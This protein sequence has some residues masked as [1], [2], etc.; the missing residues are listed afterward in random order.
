MELPLVPQ[1]F[2]SGPLY[3]EQGACAQMTLKCP[4][5]YNPRR[6]DNF[7]VSL[8]VCR[9]YLLVSCWEGKLCLKP[10][11][12]QAAEIDSWLIFCFVLPRFGQ[13][14]HDFSGT[15]E[16]LA[17]AHLSVVYEKLTLNMK[18]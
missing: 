3:V 18:T 6:E 1:V 7:V 14:L 12:P 8:S 17:L 13:G 9:L 10:S 2:T 11:F 4:S 5:Y 16:Q 15:F